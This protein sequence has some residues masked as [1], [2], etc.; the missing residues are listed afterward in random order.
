M[1]EGN[2][3]DALENLLERRLGKSTKYIAMLRSRW[4]DIVGKYFS[5]NTFPLS[6]S[7]K[8]LKIACND[9]LWAH[10][11]SMHRDEIARRCKKLLGLK[12]EPLIKTE[13][14]DVS[15]LKRQFSFESQQKSGEILIDISGL[16]ARSLRELA[17]HQK[18][19]FLKEFLERLSDSL[20]NEDQ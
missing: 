10:Q 11:L 2:I 14:K 7:S 4:E 13:I 1:K 12:R 3:K 17:E 16:D 8:T 20:K 9:A 6:M 19:D 5:E 15:W 18:Y